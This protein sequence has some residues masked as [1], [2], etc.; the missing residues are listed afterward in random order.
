MLHQV[1]KIAR[2]IGD[3]GQEAAA[4]SIPHIQLPINLLAQGNVMRNGERRRVLD[5]KNAKAVSFQIAKLRF[6]QLASESKEVGGCGDHW[7]GDV[8]VCVTGT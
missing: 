5:K 3:I 1:K 8:C 2:Q 7:L 6:L 4:H